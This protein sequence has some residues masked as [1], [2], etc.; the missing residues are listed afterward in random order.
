MKLRPTQWIIVG[1]ILL[2][3]FHPEFDWTKKVS[4]FGVLLVDRSESMRNLSL[5]K[6]GSSLPLKR[7]EFS[8]N[9]PGTAIGEGLLLA[10]E[11]YENTSFILLYSD[12]A[13]TRGK[14]PIGAAAEIDVPV[15]VFYPDQRPETA[16][17]IS[18]FGPSNIEE[19][20]SAVFKVHYLGPSPSIIRVLSGEMEKER[21]VRGEGVVEFSLF[22]DVGLHNFEFSLISKDKTIARTYR[23]LYVS[24]RTKVL[25]YSGRLDWN[26]KFLYRYFEDKGCRVKGIWKRDKKMHSFSAYDIICLINPEEGIE[27]KLDTYIK[28][29]GTTIIVN[30][31]LLSADFLPLIAPQVTLSST[32][33]PIRYSLKPTGIR[34]GAGEVTLMGEIVAYT[35]NYGKGRVVQFTCLDPWRLRLVG[36]GVYH[37][38]FFWEVMQTLMR[39]L[40]PDQLTISYPDRL[41]EG[42]EVM[43]ISGPIKPDSFIWNKKYIPVTGD[44]IIIPP[45]DEGV[46][47]FE[48]AFPSSTVVGSLEVVKRERDR[49]ELDTTMLNAIASISGGGRWMEDFDPSDFDSRAFRHKSEIIYINLRHNWLFLSFFFFI[50]FIDWYLWMK[51]K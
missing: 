37:K 46:H 12:G 9:E 6:I 8:I 18:V 23:N 14:S 17:F 38:D 2:L 28:N 20:D 51:G 43:I 1:L 45:P 49:M 41:L 39:Y 7:M 27:R 4:P 34:R 11:R 21:E 29:G 24:E 5:P 3:I 22:L 26:Y 16:G 25:I 30:S 10:K 48:I 15:Y 32:E 33:L 50:L 31:S 40:S 19:G 44:T 36:K 13:N 35:M 42:E 47:R